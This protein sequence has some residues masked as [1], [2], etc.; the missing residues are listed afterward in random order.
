M[1][2]GF[3]TSTLLHSSQHTYCAL[4]YF[5]DC[6]SIPPLLP[7]LPSP[8][9]PLDVEDVDTRNP[10]SARSFHSLGPATLVAAAIVSHCFPLAHSSDMS[11]IH[12]YRC[13][14]RRTHQVS[15][16]EKRVKERHRIAAAATAAVSTP[17]FLR[18]MSLLPYCC[19]AAAGASSY[20]ERCCACCCFWVN[21]LCQQQT[22][23]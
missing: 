17:L 16:R 7:P 3:S 20:S 4:L 5:L 13:E 19:R 15:E 6:F 18:S 10:L 9:L 23:G 21:A 8:R 12:T 22:C 11:P 14:C 2:V 1:V